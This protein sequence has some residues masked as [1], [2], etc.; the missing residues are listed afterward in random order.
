MANFATSNISGVNFTQI[1]TP[2]GTDDYDFGSAPPA[3]LGTI[4]LANDGSAWVMVVLGTGGTTGPGYT[5]KY[6]ED[7]L[8]VMLSTSND[9][10]GDMV[11]V[12]ACAAAAIGDYIWLQVKGTCPAIRVAALCAE[13]AALT[14]TATGGELDDAS[15]LVVQGMIITTTAVGAGVQPGILNWPW[16]TAT[17]GP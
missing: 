11:G 12:P 8:A 9:T 6:D 13:N 17:A 7:F 1:Y 10:F 4:V 3:A 5:C 16:I 2:P 14:T 15:G